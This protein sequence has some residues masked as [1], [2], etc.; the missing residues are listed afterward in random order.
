MR[1]KYAEKVVVIV[2]ECSVPGDD[3]GHWG[4]ANARAE[5][6]LRRR[7]DHFRAVRL[8]LL[9]DGDDVVSRRRDCRSSSPL[10]VSTSRVSA[11]HGRLAATCF[12][13]PLM[14]V[15]DAFWCRRNVVIAL[16]AIF[17]RDRRETA[18][19][20]STNSGRSQKSIDEPGP[21]VGSLVVEGK[22]A[23]PRRGPFG[24]HAD[25]VEE[26]RGE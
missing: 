24:Q 13:Q 10:A 16:L 25:S 23:Q 14:E 11:S 6:R 9:A 7:R 1:E 26:K 8:A 5:K 12:A 22:A 18:P 17:A 3:Y 4:A 15:A 21:L 19:H 20:K 2:P